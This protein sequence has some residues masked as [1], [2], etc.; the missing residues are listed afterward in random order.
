MEQSSGL[1]NE[2][3]YRYK[4]GNENGTLVR[5]IVKYEAFLRQIVWILAIVLNLLVLFSMS[6]RNE[7][8]INSSDLDG[9]SETGTRILILVIGITVFVLLL[10]ITAPLIFLK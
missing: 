10:S 2:M 9:L 1:I 6:S 5:L 4:I 8:R 7:S 3:Y